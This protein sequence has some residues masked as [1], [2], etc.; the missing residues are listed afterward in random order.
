MEEFESKFISTKFVYEEI[1]DSPKRVEILREILDENIVNK[2]LSSN[3]NLL[4]C[5]Q[6]LILSKKQEYHLFRKYNYLKYR[7]IKISKNKKIGKTKA[8]IEINKKLKDLLKVRELLIKC[9]L[10]LIVRN[11]SKYFHQETFNYEEFFS[12]GYFHMLRA[13]D[14]FDHTRNFKFS[15]YFI[16]VLFTN[17]IKDKMTLEKHSNL[18]PIEDSN[19]Y[20]DSLFES[21]FR[22]KN[23]KYNKDF[24]EK[25]LKILEEK[26]EK[27]KTRLDIFKKYYG[28][29]GEERKNSVE[30]SKML[31][32]SKSRVQQ[33]SSDILKQLKKI[34]INYD[35]IS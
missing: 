18:Q 30:I 21:Y 33:I 20:D 29:C 15:T 6:G 9:N 27:Y 10:R 13:I 16:N 28:I 23:E 8:K 12:N 19:I 26:N 14:C 11:V 32:I 4:T 17:L 24:I 25:I 22:E 7:I 35:P 3:S 31:N 1:F 2:I 5:N 34:K